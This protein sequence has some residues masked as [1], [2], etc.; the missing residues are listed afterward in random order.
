MKILSPFASKEEVY[1]IVQAGADELYCGIIP[2]DWAKKYSTLEILSRRGG[3]ESN[4]TSYGELKEA[5]TVAHSMGVPVFV[6]LNVPYVSRQY[7]FIMTI[8]DRLCDIKADGFIVID[9]GLLLLMR[10]HNIKQEI[11]IGTLG[12]VFNS[13]AAG[14][15]EKL[16]ASRIVLPRDLTLKEIE[17]LIKNAQPSRISFEAFILNTLCCNIDGFCGF[18]H[19]VLLSANKACQS[20]D[21]ISFLYTYDTSLKGSGCEISFSKEK[22]NATNKRRILF[23]NNNSPEAKKQRYSDACG[24]C[25][26][27]ELNKI[28]I[29]Y[30]KIVERG[31]EKEEKVRFVR[32]LKNAIDL[33][34]N[35]PT[36]NKYQRE[37]RQLYQC[38]FK[39]NCSS[40]PCYYA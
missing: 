8:V 25:S 12:N 22:F 17:I 2:S 36:E 13:M 34:K 30:L 11:H 19:N 21:N 27:M 29:K 1:P 15:Y 7:A 18:F 40:V 39:E 28:G 5:I 4:F 23:A 16:G 9:I 33:L 31:R 35:N 24:A 6:T 38:I 14:F 20:A 37:V 10:K 32:F 3:S 26:I